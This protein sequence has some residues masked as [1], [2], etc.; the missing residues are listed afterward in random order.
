MR[1]KPAQ[2]KTASDLKD[3]AAE[4]KQYNLSSNYEGEAYDIMLRASL[5]RM[6][7]SLS[8]ASF[9]MAMYDWMSHFALSPAKQIDLMQKGFKNLNQF[10]T[11]FFTETGWIDKKFSQLNLCETKTEDPRFNKSVWEVFPFNLYA[12]YFLLCENWIND[13]TT[14]AR[15]V[16]KH[17][18]RIVNFTARQILDIFSP[19]NYIFTNPEVLS[20]TIQQGGAN[21][22]DGWNN[23]LEDYQRIINKCPPAGTDHF[24]P[25][26]QVATTPG[27][28]IYRNHLMEL[29]QYTPQK[30]V[31]PE[32]ILIVPAWIMKYYIL[33]LSQK[34][35]LVK[36]LVDHGHTVFMISWKNPKSEDRNLGLEDYRTDGIMRALSV[37]RD[38]IPH[39]KIHA[40]GYCLGGTLLMIAAASMA[41]AGQDWL[42]SITLFAAQVDFRDPGEL[43]FFIDQS[44]VTWLEDIMWERGYL[45]GSQMAGAFN[46]LRSNDLVWSRMIHDYLL[47]KRRPINDLM[48]WNS[49]TTRL[50]FRM[51]SEYLHQLFLNNELVQGKYRVDKKRI[52]LVDIQV[53]MFVVGTV[54]DHVSPWRSVY[55][56]HLVTR[57]DVTFVLT[58]GG[59]NAGIVSEP[60]HKGRH[61]HILTRHVG[62]RHLSSDSWLEKATKKEDSWWLDWQRWLVSHSDKKVLFSDIEHEKYPVICDAPGTYVLEK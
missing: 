24:I 8:P 22:V 31:Y 19:S 20:A 7:F 12:K 29:I 54:K 26:V 51:H 28:V 50:P 11:Q 14:G 18:E 21:F 5:A 36:Y 42:K 13:A 49:D 53:P 25:G 55:R 3:I 41:Q 15:G 62:E 44:Q 10:F 57:T 48:A 56:I 4:N 45:D 46:M 40:T 61:Y 60:G 38:V 34:N 47:G 23:M 33:D 9:G 43:S 58:S 35:S 39:H 6:T 1:K 30:E 27:K 16:S 17:H 37:I 59:H 32:P 2:K 52:A